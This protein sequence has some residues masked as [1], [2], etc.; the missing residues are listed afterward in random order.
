M[1]YGFIKEKSS[2]AVFEKILSNQKVLKNKRLHCMGGFIYLKLLIRYLL[3][4]QKIES[5]GNEHWVV[6]TKCFVNNDGSELDIIKVSK[7]NGG[8]KIR[9]KD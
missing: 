1:D 5:M 8:T 4:N 6:M 2:F 7:A 9:L 3:D